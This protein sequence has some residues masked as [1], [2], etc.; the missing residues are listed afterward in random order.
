MELQHI[1]AAKPG[2]FLYRRA[3]FVDKYPH[4]QD[5]FRQDARNIR[6]PQ[7][8]YIALALFIEYE[9]DRV[10]TAE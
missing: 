2:Y 1:Q 9:P 4:A 3:I 5:A 8:I 7:R 10:G 6:G